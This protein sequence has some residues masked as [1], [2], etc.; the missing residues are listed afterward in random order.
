MGFRS[1]LRRSALPACA[2]VV[3]LIAGG[4]VSGPLSPG[5]V[6]PSLGARGYVEHEYFLDGV[7]HAY[8]AVGALGNDGHWSVTPSTS[9]QFRTRLIVR[10]PTDPARFNGTVIVEWMNVSAGADIDPTF[11][12][13]NAALLRAGYA[14]VGVSAQRV[15]ID[16]LRNGNPARYGSLHTPGDDY[17]YDIF[18]QAG[19]V[20]RSRIGIDPLDGLHAQ[21]VLATGESQSAFRMVTYVNA[22]QPL[23]HTFDGFLLYSRGSGAASLSA[24]TAMPPAPVMRTDQ[25][26]RIIDVQTEGDVIVLHSA[27]VRQPDDTHFRLWE[28]AGGSHADEHTLA[29]AFPSSPTTPGSLCVYRFNSANT[30]AVVS[31]AAVKLDL[32]VRTGSTPSIA[33][34]IMLQSPPTGPDPVVRDK[35]GNARGGIRLPEL[36]VPIARIDGVPNPPTPDAPPLFQSFCA[37]FGRTQSFDAAQLATL[38][39]RHEVYVTKFDAATDAAV[40]AGFVLTVDGKALKA[41]A[42][43]SSIGG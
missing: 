42:A 24:G 37:L 33:G 5:T 36:Q 28:V 15:G 18:S 23:S 6:D 21:R 25:A 10:R 19:S 27:P 1:M 34:R 39:P 16:A 13:A 32:W 4:C 3:A 8:A 40:N 41:A 31:A 26:A 20:I 17:S 14:W 35:Y 22:V 9:A 11:G 38:Y 12:A 7:A 30:W 2:V 29:R 43:A